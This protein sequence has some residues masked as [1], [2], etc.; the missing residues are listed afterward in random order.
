[1]EKLREIIRNF[2]NK[3]IVVIGDLILDHYVKGDVSRLNPEAP[4]PVVNVKEEWYDIGGAGNVASNIVSL[5]G[6]VSLFASVGKDREAEILRKI[7][8]DKKID[9]FLDENQITTCKVRVIGRNQQI[10]RFDKEET[11][12][13]FFNNETKQALLKKAE[14]SDIIIISDYAKGVITSDLISLLEPYKRKIIVNPKPKNTLLYK[15]VFLIIVNEKESL[16]MSGCFNLDSAAEKLKFMLNSPILITL[17]SKGM[18]LFSNKNVYIPTQAKEVYD[19]TGA[20]DTVISTA[21]LAI[22]SGSSLEEAAIL[23]NHAA[24]IAVSKVGT[25]QVKLEELEKEIL[26][27]EQKLKKLDELIEIVLDLKK[28]GKKI[29]WTNGCFDIFHAGH[30]YSLEKAKE[31]GDIL[32]VGLDSDESVRKIKGEGRPIYNEKE[33]AE[34]LSVIESVDFIIIFPP[35]GA[36]ECIKQLKPHVYVKSGNYNLDTINQDERRFIESYGGEIFLPKGI[37][38]LSTTK[39]IEKIKEILKKDGTF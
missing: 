13:K 19:V 6:N 9:Y 27:E 23:G 34:I 30:K 33:R 15:N 38:D 25:Y 11:S 22:A 8:Q 31:K 5:G 29:V 36:L 20:G 2:S 26:G 16:E 28:K 37:S 10:V 18:V 24:K 17:G 35:N 14:E 7:L 21:S 12:E 3:K 39:I 32:I 1:M 4:V